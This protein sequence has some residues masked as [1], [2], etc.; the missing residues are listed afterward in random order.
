MNLTARAPET[1]AAIS[2]KV[3]SEL[4]LLAISED[5]DFLL[6]QLASS[7]ERSIENFTRMAVIVNRLEEIGHPISEL[8]LMTLPYLRKIGCGQMLAQ[9]LVNFLGRPRLLSI[10]ANL[11]LSDQERLV[12]NEPFELLEGESHR[13]V[14]PTKLGDFE[15]KQLF[16]RDHIRDLAE[17]RSWLRGREERAKLKQIQ[18]PATEAVVIDKKQHGIRVGS[19]FISASELAIY[20]SQLQ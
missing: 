4:E 8:K 3:R 19:R 6:Q 15:V 2:T 5:V 16:A 1:M 13:L 20:L 17:Q 18:E 10:A 14:S 7:V 9:L 11:P 12:N